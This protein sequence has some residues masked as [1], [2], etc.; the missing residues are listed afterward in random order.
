MKDNPYRFEIV[1]VMVLAPLVLS[2]ETWRRW[3][4]LLSPH[5]L[6]D[7]V[8]FLLAGVAAVK[9][10]RRDAGA[11]LLWLFA[12]GGGMLLISLSLWG[13]IYDYASGDPSGV[14]MP[15]VIAFK[16]TGVLLVGLASRRAFR[17]AG[18][19]QLQREVHS[20]ILGDTR[21]GSQVTS[22]P[23]RSERER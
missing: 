9:L 19:A 6:D 14:P 15:G 2:I 21:S 20:R 13:S 10:A 22:A 7:W 4:E 3:G 18:R 12:C 16:G 5:S 1:A 11:P 8:I 17:L 23:N